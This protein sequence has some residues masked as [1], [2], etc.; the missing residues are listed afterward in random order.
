MLLPVGICD[1]STEV[2]AAVAWSQMVVNYSSMLM[3]AEA[4]KARRPCRLRWT[5]RPDLTHG[6]FVV[7]HGPCCH[8]RGH[9]TPRLGMQSIPASANWNGAAKA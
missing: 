5:T 4:E 1:G 6:K 7:D 3:Q 2:A 8:V 9:N